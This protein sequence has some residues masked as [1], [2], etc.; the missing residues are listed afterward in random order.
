MT[1]RNVDEATGRL[2][3]GVEVGMDCGSRSILIFRLKWGFKFDWFVGRPLDLLDLCLSAV[4]GGER[5]ERDEVR[6]S[7]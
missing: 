2:S 6:C 7:K 4:L 1:Q 5:D 3:P